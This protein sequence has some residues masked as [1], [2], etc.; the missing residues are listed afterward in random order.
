[1]YNDNI[2]I[3]YIFDKYKTKEK[4]QIIARQSEVISKLFI[5]LSGNKPINPAREFYQ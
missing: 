3:N 2:L 1:M 5:R 4:P